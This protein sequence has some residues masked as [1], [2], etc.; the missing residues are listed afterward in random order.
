V[1]DLLREHR[2]GAFAAIRRVEGDGD[3]GQTE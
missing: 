1:T 2:D 3:S